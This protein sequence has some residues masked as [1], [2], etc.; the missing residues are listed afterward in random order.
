MGGQNG[1]IQIALEG[2]EV[3]QSLVAEVAEDGL[4]GV[5]LG[6]RHVSVVMITLNNTWGSYMESRNVV[7]V[8]V[9]TV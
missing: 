8:H 2:I 1:V 3:I 7:F 9:E 6:H 5:H 4:L